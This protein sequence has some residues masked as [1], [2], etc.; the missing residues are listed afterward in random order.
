M[1]TRT[2]KEDAMGLFYG[3]CDKYKDICF[4]TT[5]V[6]RTNRLKENDLNIAKEKE[7]KG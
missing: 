1:F 3:I 2:I 7:G 5:S 4:N 6:R